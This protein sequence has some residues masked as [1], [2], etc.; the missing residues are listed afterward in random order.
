MQ[1]EH[2]SVPRPHAETVDNEFAEAIRESE[3]E[4]R[5]WEAILRDT[6]AGV[7]ASE[8]MARYDITTSGDEDAVRSAAVANVQH[9]I[10]RRAR[11]SGAPGVGRRI[12]EGCN[13][14][15]YGR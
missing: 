8:I 3:A 5:R 12:A 4:M 9:H 1:N 13:R 6:R 10:D 7:P 14:L 11:Y 2:H 15:R